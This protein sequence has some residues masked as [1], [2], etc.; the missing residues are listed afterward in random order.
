MFQLQLLNLQLTRKIDNSAYPFLLV[1]FLFSCK[2]G[3]TDVTEAK[4]R[5]LAVKSWKISEIYVDDVAR[6][7]E[8][9]LI[10]HFGGVD[11]GRYM[12][13]AAFSSDGFFVGYFNGETAPL[14][15][16]YG[17]KAESIV[18]TDAD[19]A[20]KS[21]EWVVVPSSVTENSFEMTTSTKAYNFPAITTIRMLFVADK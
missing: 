20:V 3:A 21:G 18:L 12:E 11:F 6:F 9:K 13:H 15:L 10:P 19:P 1:V 7:K 4:E 5:L 8:G 2:K 14:K 16:K 17:V